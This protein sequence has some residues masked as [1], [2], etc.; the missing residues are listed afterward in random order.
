[1]TQAWQ[2]ILRLSFCRVP[3]DSYLRLIPKPIADA[4]LRS[5]S[6]QRHAFAVSCA[7]LAVERCAHCALG[8][9]D[10]AEHTLPALRDHVRAAAGAREAESIDR[11]LARREDALYAQLCAMR[12]ENGDAPYGEF[13]RISTQ[14]HAVRALRAALS[15]EAVA[16]AASAA[17]ETISATRS[18]ADVEQLA[19]RLLAP[20]S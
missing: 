12:A 16:A 13:V 7:D 10:G 8:I 6:G 17:F 9:D 1:M 20:L 5:S 18:E 14:R 3:S 19:S 2:T 15:H 11:M 4:I